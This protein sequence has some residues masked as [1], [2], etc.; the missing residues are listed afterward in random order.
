[1]CFPLVSG[2]GLLFGQVSLNAKTME[3]DTN[4]QIY[5]ALL[6]VYSVFT[7]VWGQKIFTDREWSRWTL[8]LRG[9]K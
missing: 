6:S 7:H 2:A 8:L 5:S 1:M 9:I 3:K 4:T